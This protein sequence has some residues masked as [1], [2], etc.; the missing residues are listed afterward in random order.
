MPQLSVIIP[1]YNKAE[2]IAQTL[3]S[4]ISQSFSNWEALVVDDGST[5]GS[6]NIITQF[7][8]ND[9][10]IKFIQR[11]TLPRGGSA[12]RNIGI[13]N[14]SGKYMMFF[15]SDD[16]MAPAC[17]QQRFNMM[18]QRSH[19]DF[20]VFPVGTFINV[21]GDNKMVWTPRKRNHLKAFLRHSLPWNIMSPIWK[22]EFVKE[23]LKGFD[24][25]FPR[26]QDVEF[27]TCALLCSGVKYRTVRSVKP[28][29]FY[30][31]NEQRSNLNYF[32]MLEN[33]LAGIELYISKFEKII[34]K[35]SL[36]RNLRGTFFSFL[37]QINYYKAVN[38]ITLLDYRVMLDCIDSIVIK[39]KVFSEKDWNRIS[40]YNRLYQK[41]WWRIKGFNWLSKSIFIWM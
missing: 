7:S 37:T 5:D 39:S 13:A 17:L 9:P 16:V 27:H 11:Q 3:Q 2:Y 35:R 12:C 24:P 28:E 6:Q 40:H 23:Q 33:M 30:R 4:L 18:Q 31:I 1:N 8:A 21:V 19:L 20:A 25:L 34:S 29:C 10:R 32:Q 22:T 15:D 26:L 14:S 38:S 36:K 41:G